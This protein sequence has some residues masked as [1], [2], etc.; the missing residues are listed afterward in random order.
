MTLSGN[1]LPTMKTMKT[2]PDNNQRFFVWKFH[3]LR[4]YLIGD[5]IDHR[6]DI[7]GIPIGTK[8]LADKLCQMLNDV[9]EKS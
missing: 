6:D 1:C 8:R 3:K 4:E 5:R 2:K 9:W 7:L